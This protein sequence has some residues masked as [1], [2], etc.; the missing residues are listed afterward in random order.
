MSANAIRNTPKNVSAVVPFAPK[1][2][3]AAVFHRGR[4][5]EAERQVGLPVMA[6]EPNLAGQGQRF[7]YFTA[8]TEITGGVPLLWKGRCRAT[9]NMRTRV[10]LDENPV[11]G[12][13]GRA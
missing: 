7:R 12:E 3:L 10:N 11:W 6:A 5:D 1:L 13:A 9:I 2:F 4:A 8:Y